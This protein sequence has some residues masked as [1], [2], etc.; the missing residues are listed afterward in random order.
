MLSTRAM[1]AVDNKGTPNVEHH[2]NL[3][4][5]LIR[6]LYACDAASLELCWERRI[7]Q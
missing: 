5:Y 2:P 1:V 3:I 7:G 6:K 4:P